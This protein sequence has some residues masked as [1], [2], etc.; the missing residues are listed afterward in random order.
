MKKILLIEDEEAIRIVLRS[1]IQRAGL[2]VT[3][4]ADLESAYHEFNSGYDVLVVDVSLPDGSGLDF[5]NSV[6]ESGYA[7]KTILMTGHTD[8]DASGIGVDHILIKPFPINIFL[9]LVKS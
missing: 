3:A 4:C 9:D 8:V 7:G 6:H 1:V 2:Q 5:V